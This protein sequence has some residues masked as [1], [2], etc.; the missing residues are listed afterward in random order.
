M[1]RSFRRGECVTLREHGYQRAVARES[2]KSGVDERR[3]VAV[4]I[5]DCEERINELRAAD[6]TFDETPAVGWDLFE[7]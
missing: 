4:S 2:H 6:F 5:A 7:E 3:E 1:Y